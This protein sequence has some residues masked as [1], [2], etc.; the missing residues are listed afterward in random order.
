MFAAR[1]RQHGFTPSKVAEMG[2]A[3]GVASAF[4]VGFGVMP[5]HVRTSG[6]ASKVFYAGGKD[7]KLHTPMRDRQRYLARFAT[8][9]E[10]GATM[11]E[12]QA[13]ADFEVAMLEPTRSMMREFEDPDSVWAFAPEKW[14]AHLF[15][16]P[17]DYYCDV[18]CLSDYSVLARS[19]ACTGL[20]R[21]VVSCVGFRDLVVVRP[22]VEQQ[23]QTP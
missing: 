4:G 6:L 10:Q 13:A 2:V 9:E 11:T 21:C 22:A 14:Q 5:T 19:R 17:E 16:S 20:T 15:S 7:S 3:A 12:L 23:R 1:C 8:W 18:R